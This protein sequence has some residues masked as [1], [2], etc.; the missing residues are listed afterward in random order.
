[1]R[2]LDFLKEARKKAMKASEDENKAAAAEPSVPSSTEAKGK[3]PA[4]PIGPSKPAGQVYPTSSRTGPKNWDKIGAGEDEDEG[5]DINV[6][7]KQLY[8]GATPEQQRAMMKSYLE[9]N[10]TTLSTDWNDVKGRTVT[11]V[12]PEGSEIKDF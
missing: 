6:F 3:A 10:G 8:K 12:V 2:R 4:E 1:M 5:K 9:S 7:F 11:T